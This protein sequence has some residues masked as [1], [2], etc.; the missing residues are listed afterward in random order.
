MAAFSHPRGLS[1]AHLRGLSPRISEVIAGS[2]PTDFYT[3]TLLHGYQSAPVLVGDL[4]GLSPVRVGT[5]PARRGQTLRN[6]AS[7]DPFVE[8]CAYPLTPSRGD[9]VCGRHLQARLLGGLGTDKRRAARD[10]GE[11]PR[12]PRQ[13]DN[14]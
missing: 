12:H 13:A 3:S 8:A 14:D 7:T 9:A 10:L 6:L 11:S 1:P 2:V 5:G 4:W